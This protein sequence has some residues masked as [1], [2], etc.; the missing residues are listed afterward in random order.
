[1]ENECFVVAFGKEPHCG[2]AESWNESAFHGDYETFQFEFLYPLSFSYECNT[3]YLCMAM[4]VC[5]VC[6]RDDDA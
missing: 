1:M 4:C 3:Q 2:K 6:V 5:V